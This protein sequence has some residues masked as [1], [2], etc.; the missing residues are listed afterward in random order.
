MSLCRRRS[1]RVSRALHR[2]L[3][4]TGVTLCHRRSYGVP[5]ALHRALT[6]TGDPDCA[7]EDH[8]AYPDG[9][10]TR[11]AAARGLP[12]RPYQFSVQSLASHTGAQNDKETWERGRPC[13]RRPLGRLSCLFQASVPQT[14]SRFQEHSTPGQLPSRTRRQ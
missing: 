7:A 11:G 12:T 14:R 2:A 5:R 10:W 9:C 4:P 6:P 1:Y 3:T 8:T 13:S